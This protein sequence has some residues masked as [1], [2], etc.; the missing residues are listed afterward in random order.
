MYTNNSLVYSNNTKQIHNN[1]RQIYNNTRIKNTNI[2]KK[3]LLKI[4][5][6]S[7]LK[8]VNCDQHILRDLNFIEKEK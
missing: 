4:C 5:A 1:T 3:N 2:T 6:H 8:W 7:N